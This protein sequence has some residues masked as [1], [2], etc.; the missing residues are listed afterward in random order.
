MLGEE[1]RSYQSEG[2]AV[3]KNRH[4]PLAQLGADDVR[5]LG[6]ADTVEH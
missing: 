4:A 5:A 1:K 3:H 6:G 2:R